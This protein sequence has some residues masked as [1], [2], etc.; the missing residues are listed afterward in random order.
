MNRTGQAGSSD[1]ESGETEESLSVVLCR[2]QFRKYTRIAEIT[3]NPVDQ[4]TDTA[5]V[6]TTKM[7]KQFDAVLMMRSIRDRISNE[8]DG[9]NFQ[10][11]QTYFQ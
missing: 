8:I 9:M 7:N 1:F 5:P 4:Q 3:D 6:A 10:E 2:N 11:Q